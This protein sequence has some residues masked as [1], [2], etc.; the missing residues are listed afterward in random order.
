MP[1]VTLISEPLPHDCLFRVRHR[2]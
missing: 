2:A 1:A